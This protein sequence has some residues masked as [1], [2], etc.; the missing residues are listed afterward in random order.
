M[1]KLRELVP[2]LSN[3]KIKMVAL[4]KDYTYDISSLEH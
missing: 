2:E 4:S 3:K 1:E